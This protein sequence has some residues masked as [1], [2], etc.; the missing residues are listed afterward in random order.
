M[1][2][3]TKAS[4]KSS[5]SLIHN[6]DYSGPATLVLTNPE[7]GVSIEVKVHGPDFLELCEAVATDNIMDKIEKALER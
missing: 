3:T 2:H 1:A 6:S 4:P 5:L 7:T